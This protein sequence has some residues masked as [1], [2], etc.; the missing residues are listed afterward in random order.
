VLRPLTGL[1]VFGHPLGAGPIVLSVVLHMLYGVIVTV[2][3]LYA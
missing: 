3:I 1:P 2:V